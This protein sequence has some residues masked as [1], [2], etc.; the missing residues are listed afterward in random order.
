MF[1]WGNQETDMAFSPRGQVEVS[2][3]CH[4]PA[5]HPPPHTR[6]SLPFS[7]SFSI[8]VTK[9]ASSVA[10]ETG[11]FN[12]D[13]GTRGKGR[14]ALFRPCDE[15]FSPCM[16]NRQT[17][18]PKPNNRAHP[19]P[20]DYVQWSFWHH[21]F[22]SFI[23]LCSSHHGYLSHCCTAFLTSTAETTDSQIKQGRHTC[24]ANSNW[25]YAW[26]NKHTYFAYTLWKIH[27]AE[28]TI[29][30]VLFPYLG[31]HP[32]LFGLAQQG[33]E[34]KMA[35]HHGNCVCRSATAVMYVVTLLTLWWTLWAVEHPDRPALTVLPLCVPYRF[36]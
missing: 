6:P 11:F 7:A 33:G 2:I 22:A 8:P 35:D 17:Y 27:K 15:G 18:G 28:H 12:G 30:F 14:A 31:S 10:K 9:R 1:S 34:K 26:P 19:L 5:L 21:H 29:L 36:S 4:A 3:E 23:M 13:A 24:D 20:P 16:F 32:P 25:K